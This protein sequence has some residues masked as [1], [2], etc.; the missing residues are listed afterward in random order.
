MATTFVL[1]ADETVFPIIIYINSTSLQLFWCKCYHPS[2]IE[3]L[4]CILKFTSYL[5]FAVLLTLTPTTVVLLGIL[6]HNS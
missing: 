5:H 3:Y 6:L 1:R 4:C 2:R